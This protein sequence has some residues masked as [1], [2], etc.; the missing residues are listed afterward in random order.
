MATWRSWV[1]VAALVSAACG[2]TPSEEQQRPA[3]ETTP[4]D[5]ATSVYDAAATHDGPNDAGAPSDAS[6]SEEDESADVAVPISPAPP[7]VV[8]AA[9]FETIDNLPFLSLDEQARHASSYDRAANNSDLGNA[10][11]VDATGNA[12]LLDARGPGCVYRIWFTGFAATDKIHFYFDDEKTPR[13]DLLL[14][15]LFTGESPPF[16]FPLAGDYKSSSG[17]FFS[18]VPL[19][20]AKSL[21]ITATPDTRLYY[22]I[23]YHALPA[24]SAITSWTGT[25]DLSAARAIWSAAGSDPKANGQDGGANGTA[26]E[27]TFDLAPKQMQTLFDGIGPGEISA[28]ELRIPGLPGRGDG[29]ADAQAPATLGP[30]ADVLDQLL[31]TISWDNEATPSVAAPVGSLFALGDLGAGSSGGLMAGMRADGTLYLYFPMP[32]A[33]HAQIQLTNPGKMPVTGLW[34]RVERRP[35]PFSYDTVGTFAVDYHVTNSSSGAD[36]PLLDT[37]GSGKVVGVV[38]SESRAACSNCSQ[39][40]YLEG[41]EHVLV[42]GARTPVVMGTGTEDFFN[43]GFYF[44]LGPFG[45]PTH[46]NVVHAAMTNYDGTSM[47]RFFITDPISFRDHVRLSLQHGPTDNDA[48][49]ASSLVY[50]YHQNR[51]RIALSDALNVGDPVSEPAHRYKITNATWS[52]SLTATWEGEFSTQS[53]TATGRSHKGSSSFVLQIDPANSGVILRRLLNQGTGNQRAS[54]F[55]DGTL[56]GDW[57][58]PGSNLNH[59]WREEDFAI[60]SSM[61]VGKSSVLIEIRFVS[62]D[63]DWTE[64][65]YEAYSQFP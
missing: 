49:V 36:L 38:V 30:L 3:V 43:G 15:Q 21:R 50:Y 20:Y 62:S 14:T 59:A 47:Y 29:G 55:A 48:V 42:D 5:A 40:D 58:S 37:A 13:I 27:S 4:A 45:L 23:D 61:T 16:S 2:S 26:S 63:V 32:F 1:T 41:N 11:G 31:M 6:V 10:Y 34:A 17:G 46:G 9:A 7:A 8:G 65:E 54:V 22:N 25:E 35:F 52:G 56:V 53:F 28:I 57:L 33:A 51:V 60:P 12:I 44:E 64:F 39:R 19:P 24:D 18:Y